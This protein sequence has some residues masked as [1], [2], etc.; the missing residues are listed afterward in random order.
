MVP[1]TY[2]GHRLPRGWFPHCLIWACTP[3]HPSATSMAISG[4]I[5][6]SC[7]FICFITKILVPRIT[8]ARGCRGVPGSSRSSSFQC[9]AAHLLWRVLTPSTQG[10][11]ALRPGFPQHLVQRRRTAFPSAHPAGMRMAQGQS[12]PLHPSFRSRELWMQL[13]TLGSGNPL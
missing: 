10:Q 2:H 4:V 8:T 12:P 6:S 3:K 9:P 1:Y 11:L 7:Y 5:Q 13:W